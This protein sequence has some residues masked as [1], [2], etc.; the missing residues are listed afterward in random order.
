MID[1]NCNQYYMSKRLH[2][3]PLA[4]VIAP[5]PGILSFAVNR[6][7]RWGKSAAAS[8]TPSCEDQPTTADEKPIIEIEK[9]VLVRKTTELASLLERREEVLRR[10]EHA[11][12]KVSNPSF[13][14]N[15]I[16][17]YTCYGV[18]TACRLDGIW[19]TRHLATNLDR[20]L[21]RCCYDR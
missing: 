8:S 15:I 19:A 17:V 5:S 9:V 16:M 3:S 14:V 11:H 13:S 20:R 12:I 7:W 18:T 2:I 6:L 1:R 21:H 4:P 10:L